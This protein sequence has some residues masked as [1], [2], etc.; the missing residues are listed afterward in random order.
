VTVRLIGERIDTG[1]VHYQRHVAPAAADNFSTY[2]YLQLAAALPLLVQAARNAIAGKLQVH[3][4]GDDL[5][6][7]SQRPRLG[8]L[9]R[10]VVAGH[11]HWPR[12]E[13]S[14]RLDYS[15]FL[16]LTLRATTDTY[17]TLYGRR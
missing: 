6:L 9:V 4:I 12:L 2:L 17:A 11:S 13:T 3:P 7:S 8:R 14:I 5:D 10:P 1:G 15:S 16:G